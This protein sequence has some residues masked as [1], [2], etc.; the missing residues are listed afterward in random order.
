MLL[1]HR[2]C[3]SWHTWSDT[4]LLSTNKN[5]HRAAERAGQKREGRLADF[6]PPPEAAAAAEGGA[7]GK[8]KKGGKKGKGGSQGEKSLRELSA[9]LLAKASG[10]GEKRKEQQGGAPGGGGFVEAQVAQ[11]QPHKKKLKKGKQ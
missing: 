11:E 4:P 6:V 10:K 1:A 7:G 2:C 3:N 5:T 9:G 8:K